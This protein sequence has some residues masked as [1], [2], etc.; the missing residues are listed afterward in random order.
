MTK[1]RKKGA[2]RAVLSL[3][4]PLGFLFSFTSYLPCCFAALPL[5]LS[6]DSNGNLS[7]H[8]FLSCC[9]AYSCKIPSELIRKVETFCIYCV[10]KWIW[11][12]LQ[13]RNCRTQWGRSRSRNSCSTSPLVRVE[14]VSPELL[15]Y[16]LATCIYYLCII[17]NYKLSQ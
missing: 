12:R 2:Y 7:W 10:L 1:K 4:A 13:R 14:I 5:Q 15:R 11:C 16:Q 8:L 17:Y 9:Y 6:L 3:G